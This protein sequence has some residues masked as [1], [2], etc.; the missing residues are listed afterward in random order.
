MWHLTACKISVGLSF[1]IKKKNE[2]FDLIIVLML[3]LLIQ[4]YHNN[5]FIFDPIQERETN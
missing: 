1:L 5:H 3:L 2:I 4:R